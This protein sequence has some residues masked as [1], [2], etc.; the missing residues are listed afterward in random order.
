MTAS[1]ADQVR[2]DGKVVLITGASSG[3]GEAM[4]TGFARQGADIAVCGRRLDRVQATAASVQE[5]GRRAIAVQTDV[6]NPQDCERF[7]QAAIEQLGRIDVLINNAGIGTAAPMTRENPEDFRRVIEVNLNGAYWMSQSAVRRMPDGGAIINIASVLGSM[8]T[9]LPQAAYSASK[10]GMLGLTMDLAAQLT[11][12]K[13]IRV[14]AIAPGYFLTE[15]TEPQ[16]DFMQGVADRIPAGR[17]GK[18][19]EVVNAAIFLASDAASY[20]SGANLP[21]DG[22]L[23]VT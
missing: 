6:S 18:I 9:G 21:V 10:A 5:L 12:R 23:L 11:G 1:F 7:A 8:T 16:K 20:I 13:G 17:L 19:S 22:G 4:A 2:F 15:M 14:N 3:F